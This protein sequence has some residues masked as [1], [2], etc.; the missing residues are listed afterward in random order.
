[1]YFTIDHHNGVPVSSQIIEQLKY[2]IVSGSLAHGE[3]LP[4]VRS[5]AEELQINATTVARVYRQM[6]TEGIVYTHPGSGTFVSARAPG[7]TVAEQRRRL[8]PLL[9]NLVVEAGRL[10]VDYDKMLAWL[11]AEVDEISVAKVGNDE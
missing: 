7:L 3:K 5:L 1:M 8:S 2:L 9:R 4:S 10:G 6:E 11:L